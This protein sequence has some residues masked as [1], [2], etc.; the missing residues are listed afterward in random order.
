MAAR[1]DGQP[2][3]PLR[4]WRDNADVDLVISA[5]MLSQLP[6]RPAEWLERNPV[7]AQALPPIFWTGWCAGISPIC[8]AWLAM[9]VCLLTDTAMREQDR[10]GTVTDTLD[11]M[12]G[13]ALPPPDAEWDWVGCAKG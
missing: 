10:T 6:I 7:R 8:W 5:N 3:H 12:R 13:A 1:R 9:P 11:L 2:Q 4:P